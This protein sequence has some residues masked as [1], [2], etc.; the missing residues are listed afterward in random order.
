M[1]TPDVIVRGKD[2]GE[3]MIIHYETARGTDIFGLAMP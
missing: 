1:K 3:G 2:N